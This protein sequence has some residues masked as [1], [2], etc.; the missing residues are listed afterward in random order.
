[1]WSSYSHASH[2]TKTFYEASI[3]SFSSFFLISHFFSFWSF[4]PL[5]PN[6]HNF[7]YIPPMLMASSRTITVFQGTKT[8]SYLQCTFP[9]TR[10]QWREKPLIGRILQ[11]DLRHRPKLTNNLSTALLCLD[12]TLKKWKLDL[13]DYLIKKGG[14]DH[15]Q[16]DSPLT[17]HS[18]IIL[19]HI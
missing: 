19:L 9:Y 3:D 16:K 4:F 14:G 2:R 8:W 11:L 7:S 15:I 18:I 10:S 6:C 12:Y 1:M 17:E 5:R 13:S